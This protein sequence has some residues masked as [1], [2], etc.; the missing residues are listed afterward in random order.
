MQQSALNSIRQ[1]HFKAAFFNSVPAQ[2]INAATFVFKNGAVT[3]EPS[4]AMS[5]AQLSPRLGFACPNALAHHNAA[6]TE[7]CSQQLHDVQ[8]SSASTDV[9]RLIS[10]DEYGLALLDAHQPKPAIVEFTEA[11]RI[12]AQVMQ[13]TDPEWAYTYLHRASAEIQNAD[14]IASR[15]DLASAKTSLDAAINDSSDPE[16]AYYQ[17][18]EKQFASTSSD[19]SVAH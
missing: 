10:H 11:I 7:M 18:L 19:T 16:Q 14:P 12:A 17:Q 3:V 4:P 15:Q 13:L 9:E 2:M 6:A 1:W 5:A 8:Q